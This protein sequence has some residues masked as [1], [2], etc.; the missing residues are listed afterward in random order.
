MFR[1]L[2]AGSIRLLCG[3]RLLPAARIP[4]T[5]AMF[6]ANHSSHLDFAVIWAALPAC[7]RGAT[8][9][10]AG[11]DYWEATA[12]RRWLAGRVF[13][14]VLIER[15]KVTATANPLA[16]MLAALDAGSSLIVF[17]E[18]TRSPDGVV[19]DFKPGLFH[20][21][22]ARPLVPLVPVLLDNLNRIVP[23]G[24]FLPVPII[25]SIVIGEPLRPVANEAKVDFLARARNAL[26][27]LAR[28]ALP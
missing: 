2:L 10:V 15:R 21:A 16:D 9:P 19:G 3:I 23:K 1:G 27:A 24:E 18:G 13:Q 6:F 17:P 14:A 25:G 12:F 28:P 20:V 26:V 5:P 8:R 4:A 11:R 22:H 7:R